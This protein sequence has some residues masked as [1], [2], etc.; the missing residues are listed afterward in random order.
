[1]TPTDQQRQ[2][3]LIRDRFTKTVNAFADYAVSY[4]AQFADSLA[5][6]ISAQPSDSAVDLACGPGTLA[7][8]FARKVRRVH[9]VDLTPAMLA[10]ARRTAES[11]GLGNLSFT[12]GDAQSLPFASGSLDISVTSYSLHHVTDPGRMI[13]EMAR[14]VKRTGRV[15]IIDIQV[16]EDAARAE[17]ANR[18][19]IMRD[20]SHTRSLPRSEFEKMFAAAGLRIL[21]T[22][23]HELPRSFDHWMHVAGWQRDD[24]AYIETRRLM[25]ST[26]AD[27]RAGF[28][29]QYS[30]A[31]PDAPDDPPDI[32]M[33]NTALFIAAGKN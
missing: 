24:K 8:Q 22:E 33:V 16:P 12:L 23:V 5:R 28:H 15:G 4:R 26:M 19:E 25:E 9:A 7:L 11:E 20:P 27:D 6:L 13:Q 3:D 2:K 18:I 10:R 30:P 14:V 21:A 1:M 29:P 32:N 31:N 17:I